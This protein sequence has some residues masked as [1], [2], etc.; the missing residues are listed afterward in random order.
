MGRFG[1]RPL[2]RTTG[3][4]LGEAVGLAA[5]VMGV[6]AAVE[7]TVHDGD[8]LSGAQAVVDPAG[9]AVVGVEGQSSVERVLPVGG[10]L[11]RLVVLD[12]VGGPGAFGVGEVVEARGPGGA[13]ASVGVDST[14]AV[15][16]VAVEAVEVP[17]DDDAAAVG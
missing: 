15:G 16:W 8:G 10:G 1:E 6:G 9:G 5:A 3:D 4:D 7:Q 12:Q 13:G 17:A 11:D 14:E 2:V